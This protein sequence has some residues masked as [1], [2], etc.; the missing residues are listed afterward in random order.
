MIKRSVVPT[1]AEAY[2]DFRRFRKL[3]ESTFHWYKLRLSDANFLGNWETLRLDKIS[4]DMVIDAH[5]RLSQ[6]G[7]CYAN[8]AMRALRAILNFA[9]GYYEDKH[10]NQLIKQNPVDV[11]SALRIWNRETRRQ[12][13]LERLDSWLDVCLSVENETVRDWLVL[14][15][16]T[17]LRRNEGAQLTWNHVDL[18]TGV[19]TII[20]TKNHH[21]LKLP[22]SDVAWKLLE[23]RSLK[24]R[25]P[26]V[27]P[28]KW[29]TA[30][31]SPSFRLPPSFK[32]EGLQFMVH[33]L[34][35]TFVTTADALEYPREIIKRLVN[36]HEGDVTQGYIIASPE[37]LRK[38][39]QAITDSILG[40]A[41]MTK[42][43]VLRIIG[44][45]DIRT[46]NFRTITFAYAAEVYRKTRKLSESSAKRYDEREKR[47][48]YLSSKLLVDIR[49]ADI[50]YLKDVLEDSCG[51]ALQ[52]KVMQLVRAI[53][54]FAEKSWTG[55]PSLA[56]LADRTR[57]IR[58]VP[59]KPAPTIK[60]LTA[61]SKEAQAASSLVRDYAHFLLLSGLE[62]R[63][64][65]N[66]RWSQIDTKEWTIAL[67]SAGKK[68]FLLPVTKYVQLIL[69]RRQRDARSSPYVFP[70]PSRT[71]TV[72]NTPSFTNG[73]ELRGTFFATAK[74]LGL[75]CGTEI[76][77]TSLHACLG[78]DLPTLRESMQTVEDFL[79]PQILPAVL[80][81]VKKARRLAAAR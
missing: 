7:P 76:G 4:K 24:R 38:P 48:T 58:F 28:G 40:T 73:R 12:S 56:P 39:M 26:Y 15:L 3:K 72:N 51:S 69:R 65:R 81:E 79:R 52:Y 8:G 11:L 54:K 35:R 22:L 67:A 31:I 47:M 6:N 63:E 77:R 32:S 62:R 59:E 19:I 45:G 25:G 42:D 13:T 27:F 43:E 64:V 68:T 61:W 33:D 46:E 41:G 21:I 74:E 23:I 9:K 60:D 36:H 14:L 50:D 44:G 55:M 71:S 70:S 49:P 53:L 75:F 10:G 2:A 5:A 57:A 17:G 1:L 20:D 29:E 30:P 16:L 80:N 37:R 18:R 66:L 34:R 78:G